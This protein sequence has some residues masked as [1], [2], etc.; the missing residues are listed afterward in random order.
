VSSR[1]A[2]HHAGLSTQSFTIEVDL[3]LAETDVV[4]IRATQNSG[5]TKDTTVSSATR[6]QIT[7]ES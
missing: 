2:Q 4:S 7:Q 5:S 3:L 1:T 6:L